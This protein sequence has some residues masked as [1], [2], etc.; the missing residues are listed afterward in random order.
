VR[1]STTKVITPE[2]AVQLLLDGDTLAVG[3]FVGIAVPEELLIALEQ[4]FRATGGP[5]DLTLV[6]AAGQGDGSARGLNHLAQEGLVRRAIGAHWGLVPALGRS[7]S[8]GGFEAIASRR[9]W[10]QS[11]LYITERCVPRLG[12]SGLELIEIAP[13]V[14]LERDVLA[15]MGFRREIAPDLRETDAAIFTDA[16]LGL[17]ERSPLTPRRA[18][19][20]PR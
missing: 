9:A 19:R 11:V 2:A 4:G 15:R 7:H 12:D 16:P 14:D 10:C 20:L 17:A 6:F 13:G 1:G 5:R 3:G 8:T 18:R